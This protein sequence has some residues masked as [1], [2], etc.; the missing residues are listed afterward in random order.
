[1]PRT[2]QFLLIAFSAALVCLIIFCSLSSFFYID[3]S[4]S[5]NGKADSNRNGNAEY[6]SLTP[7]LLDA[8]YELENSQIESLDVPIDYT[9][10]FYRVW[11]DEPHILR[12]HFYEPDREIHF[13]GYDIKESSI[14]EFLHNNPDQRLL[15]KLSFSEN[16]YFYRP[17]DKVIDTL[18]A[19]YDS[20]KCNPKNLYYNLD[21]KVIDGFIGS[22]S[23]SQK[24]KL[25]KPDKPEALPYPKTK[26]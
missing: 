22:N 11:E 21:T 17:N 23:M 9:T 10:R 19:C 7:E 3:L 24:I 6:T 16:A 26:G 2:I 4:S 12:A 20:S 15:K 8:I 5:S 18:N 13:L 25:A 1:M 14:A